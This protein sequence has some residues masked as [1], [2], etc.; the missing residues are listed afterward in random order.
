MKTGDI[1]LIPMPFTDLQSIK[2]RPGLIIFSKNPDDCIVLAITSN[3]AYSSH[4]HA[5]QIENEHVQDGVLPKTSWIRTDKVFTIHKS[6]IRKRVC[7]VR[8]EKCR[9]V[10]DAFKR[11]L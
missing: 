1:V 7:S 9:E 6:L 10:I 5:I 11:L 2:Q 3:E 8:K 4:S